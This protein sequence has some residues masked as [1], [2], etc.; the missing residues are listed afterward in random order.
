MPKI[1]IDYIKANGLDA[2]TKNFAIL[3]K[4]HSKYTNLVLL[5]YSQIDSP[6]GNPVVQRCRGIILDEANNWNVVS[7]P[8]NKFFNYGEGH[9]AEIDWDNARVYEKLDGSLMTL[10][11]YDGHWEVASS[12]V[13]D[14]SG[15]MMGS[16]TTFAQLFW[17]VWKEKGYNLPNDTNNCYMFELLTPFNRIVVRHKT[18]RIVLH[19]ARRLSDFREL[20]PIVE[21]HVNRWECVQ[22]FPLKSW[23][24]IEAAS[25][26]LDPMQAEGFVVCD[27]NYNRVKVKSPQYVAIAHVRDGL[28]TRRLLEVIRSNESSEFLLYY[29]ELASMY[30]DIK[31]KYER[32]LGQVEGFYDAIKDIDD[33]K[34]FASFATKTKFSGLLFGRKFGKIESF[35]QGIAEMTIKNLEELLSLKCIELNSGE[36]L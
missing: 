35:K 34:T 8:Y 16:E 3:V 10:Y 27:T 7:Y 33:R 36:I 31:V 25:K 21:A 26:E 29:P 1:L 23:T 15:Q 4:R 11:Y 17:Q 22:T 20:N 2:L 28:S 12:G 18:N 6:M 9:A 5:K 30:Y 24:D 19:G 14:A 13:P 32:F